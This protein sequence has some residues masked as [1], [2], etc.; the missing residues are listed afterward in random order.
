MTATVGSP[1][2]TPRP[3]ASAIGALKNVGK[4]YGKTPASGHLPACAAGE[5]NGSSEDNGAG[6]STISMISPGLDQAGRRRH[7]VDVMNRPSSPRRRRFGD[8][9]RD[10]VQKM[11]VVRDAGGATSSWQELRNRLPVFVGPPTQCGP[12]RSPTWPRWA[13]N[14]PTSTPPIGRCPAGQ[15][16]CRRDRGGRLFIGAAGC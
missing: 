4:S 11:S 1:E 3:A 13:S 12:P 16:Q 5:V 2:T 9:H 6:K 8:G 10:V 14:D 15:R 7:P